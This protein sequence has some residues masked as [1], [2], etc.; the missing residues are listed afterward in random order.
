M[1]PIETAVAV[2]HLLFAG[3]WTG[4][5]I[6]LAVAVLPLATRGDLN[7]APLAS[8]ADSTTTISRLSALLLFLTGGHLAGTRYTVDSLTGSFGGYL[9]LAM[10]ALWLVLAALVEIGASRL[11]DGTDQDKV[12]EPARAARR[13]LQLAAVVAALLLIDGGLLT[14]IA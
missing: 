14:T 5:V 3:L 9:V 4:S 8:I 2:T 13:P 11:S 12:R 10:L 1:A 6:F 7:A